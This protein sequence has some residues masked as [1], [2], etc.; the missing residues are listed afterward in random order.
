MRKAGPHFRFI[1]CLFAHAQ[2]GGSLFRSP[3]GWLFQAWGW[4]MN[5][6]TRSACSGVCYGGHHAV[7][8]HVS[9]ETEIP[10][11]RGNRESM[12][13]LCDVTTSMIL[14]VLGRPVLPSRLS[15]AVSLT[16]EGIQSFSTARQIRSIIILFFLADLGNVIFHS[17]SRARLYCRRFKHKKIQTNAYFF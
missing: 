15:A 10:G 6:L 14:S 1:F 17:W 9:A 12:S 13:K 4:K 8:G 2:D 16:V 11:G 3:D 5:C 7:R